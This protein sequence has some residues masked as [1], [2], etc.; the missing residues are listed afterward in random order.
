VVGFV[1]AVLAAGQAVAK[2]KAGEKPPLMTLPGIPQPFNQGDIYFMQGMIPHHAQ[3]L[4]MARMA[5]SH[6]A[7]QKVQLLCERIIVSQQDEIKM[8]QQWLT[9]R[10][11]WAPSAD[12]AG[13]TMNMGGMV[14]DML[15][16]GMLSDD[17][18]RALDKARGKEWDRLFLVGM[19][20]HHGGAI[21]MVEELMATWGAV[22]SDD[23]YKYAS[24]VFAD[25]TM[26]ID[27]MKAMLAEIKG[28]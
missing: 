19:I 21:T 18:M 9:D 24:D 8:M 10:G 15:M 11:Q 20:K 22:Q 17:E 28:E 6:G 3:A 16:A 14:H 7:S 1:P 2:P 27:A 26:E 4:K 13:L 25:Q 23:M 12:A 5:K